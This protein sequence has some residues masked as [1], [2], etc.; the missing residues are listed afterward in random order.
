[1]IR[2]KRYLLKLC[3]IS[4][5]FIVF[6]SNAAS[7]EKYAPKLLRFEGS[8]FGIHKPIW[9]DKSF[10][11]AQALA[12]YRKEYWNKYHGNYIKSQKL[13]EV[14]IDHLIN[15]GMGK[16]NANIKAFEAILGVE[17]DGYLSREDIRCANSFASP[18]LL[19]N[20]FV[21]YRVLYYRSRAKAHVYPGWEKRARYF[22]MNAEEPELKVSDVVLPLELEERFSH[23]AFV[24]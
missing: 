4:S 16:D 7:F 13:A 10:T 21:K 19:I 11:K 24:D 17:Q 14:L 2:C 8:G 9:G 15:A 22:F 3:F 12:I 18:V 6:S 5:F 20:S 23:V 1:M